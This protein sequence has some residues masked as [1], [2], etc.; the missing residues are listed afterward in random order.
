MDATDLPWKFTETVK[1]AKKEQTQWKE[2]RFFAQPPPP[3][4]FHAEMEERGIK[5]MVSGNIAFRG[6]FQSWLQNE[7]RYS[8][9]APP[10]RLMDRSCKGEHCSTCAKCVRCRLGLCLGF[11]GCSKCI[12]CTK[13]VARWK[14]W[15][16]GSLSATF[17]GRQ[18][19]K[20]SKK[21]PASELAED[22]PR[23]PVP[24]VRTRS[25]ENSA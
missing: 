11:G 6:R 3:P 14:R 1:A 22:V 2:E 5:T 15:S 20:T 10:Q 12:H 23:N 21:L 25:T 19:L 16:L 24:L 9:R 13:C 7:D 18:K 17:H 8:N 4:F